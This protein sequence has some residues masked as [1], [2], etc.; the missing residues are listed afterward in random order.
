MP[1]VQ[2]KK[3]FALLSKIEAMQVTLK[4]PG[5]LTILVCWVYADINEN[6]DEHKINNDI[7]MEASCHYRTKEIL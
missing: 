1:K 5:A 6:R 4:R 3:S 2:W 7:I